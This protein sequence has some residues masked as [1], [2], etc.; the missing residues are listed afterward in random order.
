M[1]M[2]R[3]EDVTIGHACEVEGCSIVCAPNET[4]CY[5]HSVMRYIGTLFDE[6]EMCRFNGVNCTHQAT[7]CNEYEVP[8]CQEC[9]HAYV[10]IQMGSGMSNSFARHG[11]A[12]Q[13]II[14][15][16]TPHPFFGR[17]TMPQSQGPDLLPPNHRWP[18]RPRGFF[19]NPI[20]G[21]APQPPYMVG[22]EDSFEEECLCNNAEHSQFNQ[23]C[24]LNE[25]REVCWG[26]NGPCDNYA[27][28][29]VAHPSDGGQVP[30]CSHC[31]LLAAVVHQ[32][33]P[34]FDGLES[35]FPGY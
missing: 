6:G 32:P 13:G 21:Q 16:T 7:V 35:L 8:M 25:E 14:P 11:L 31:A 30:M 5:D 9:H 24:P 2:D 28:T 29:T 19:G 17:G 12:N 27:V 1:S 20:T 34:H 10:R 33:P 4:R 22:E 15:R 18:Q 23:E 26:Y 3:F